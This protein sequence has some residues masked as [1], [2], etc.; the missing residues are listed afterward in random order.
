MAGTT[1]ERLTY[2]PTYVQTYF[3]TDLNRLV[4]FNGEEWVDTDGNKAD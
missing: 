1:A 2:T 4:I 3:D